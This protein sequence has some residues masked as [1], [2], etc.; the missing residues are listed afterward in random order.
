MGCAVG[1]VMGCAV[2]WVV[3]AKEAAQRTEWNA[4]FFI[5][6]VNM[7][8]ICIRTSPGMA[9]YM[10]RVGPLE[11]EGSGLNVEPPTKT[12]NAFVFYSLYP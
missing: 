6:L 7:H 3:H 1:W 8:G 10:G 9:S 4:R 12:Y 5:C 11:G 2:G